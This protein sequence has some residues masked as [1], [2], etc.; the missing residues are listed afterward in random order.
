[1]KIKGEQ[2]ESGEPGADGKSTY[3]HIKYAN[4]VGEG[5]GTP[6]TVNGNTIYLKFTDNNG[7]VVGDYIGVKADDIYEDNETIGYYDWSYFRGEDGFG[8]EYIYQL[9]DTAKNIDLPQDSDNKADYRPVGWTDGPTG[10][11]AEYPYEYMCWRKY[12]KENKV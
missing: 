10:V 8:Y 5:E 1:M 6:V 4:K 7:E 12:D 2:G 3:L 11:S 9:S